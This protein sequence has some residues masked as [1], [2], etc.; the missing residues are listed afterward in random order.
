MG[1][2]DFRKKHTKN[3]QNPQASD[4]LVRGDA[5]VI[6]SDEEAQLF[7]K[8]IGDAYVQA[9]QLELTEEEWNSMSITDGAEMWRLYCWYHSRVIPDDT[10]EK[11]SR[12]REKMNRLGA[13]LAAKILKAEEVY[14]L[15]NKRTGEPHLFSN[16]VKQEEG[17]LCTPPDIRIFTKAYVGYQ[18]KNYPETLFEMKKIE[19]GADGKGIENFLGECF[20]LNGAQGV[21]I[22]GGQT[23]I[24]AEMLV[25]PPDFSGVQQISVPVMN[26]DLMRWMLLMAQFAETETEDEKLIYKLYYRFMSQEIVKAKFLV[27]MKP[28][29]DFP[30]TADGAGN[31]TLKSGAE[32]M[33]ATMKG[34]YDR[35]AVI[36]YTDWKRL[37]QCYDGWNG[38]IMTL[39]QII[40]V[41]DVA[42]NPT[43]HPQLGF[44]IGRDMYEDIMKYT[45]KE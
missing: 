19:K 1:L 39:A 2:F 14:C 20:Y 5:D 42:V 30:E 25:A 12:S 16:T 21:E 38:S 7:T 45:E 18:G 41:Y 24:S 27:P 4:A 13:V 32:F 37:R 3:T 23:A 6:T 36:M 15:Y 9:R 43:D 22:N 11:R 17:Y 35:D 44:Y 31:I 29:K 40:D 28:G 33:V 34:K 10:E 8:T 26:P